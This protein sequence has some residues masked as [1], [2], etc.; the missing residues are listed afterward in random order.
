MK[1][2]GQIA[3]VYTLH[4]KEDAL[5]TDLRTYRNRVPAVS[6]KSVST[7]GV[8]TIAYFDNDKRTHVS[9]YARRRESLACRRQRQSAQLSR[10]ME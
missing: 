1:C 9:M 2:L 7:A 6:Y 4:R 8:E 10:R 5:Q 3:L